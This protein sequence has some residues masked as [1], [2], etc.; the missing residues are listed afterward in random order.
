[1]NI[2]EWYD[3]D[4]TVKEMASIGGKSIYAIR[5][6]LLKHKLNYKHVRGSKADIPEW[7][8]EDFTIA[9]MA[10]I[11][12]KSKGTIR[13]YLLGHKLKY[14]HANEAR[15]DIVKLY[16]HNSKI[17]KIA[18]KSVART[19]IPE[20]YDPNST[21]QEMADKAGKSYS[22]ISVILKRLNLSYKYKTTVSK[23]LH[24]RQ[25][26]I[27][28]FMQYYNENLTVKEISLLSKIPE[29]KVRSFLNGH[30]LKYRKIYKDFLIGEWY[31]PN[32]TAEEM[33]FE[34]GISLAD[35]Y[36]LLYRRNL[37]YARIKNKFTVL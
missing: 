6:Y 24:K 36:A 15:A 9:G 8:N 21:I 30:H 37:S 20:W 18:V 3:E 25:Y 35:L 5:K 2:P 17:Q 22:R 31:S 12:G 1:M 10:T 27:H 14:K 4:Y 13:N 33:S 28:N 23:K 32:K 7:Y 29:K 11:S 26:N 19:D 16:D 34:S